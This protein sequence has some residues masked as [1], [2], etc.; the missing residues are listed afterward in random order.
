MVAR[1]WSQ[2]T[3]QDGHASLPALPCGACSL[4][5]TPPSWGR[6]QPPLSGCRAWEG[7]GAR[8]RALPPSS[9]ASAGTEGRHAGHATL[10][11]RQAVGSGFKSLALAPPAPVPGSSVWFHPARR[12]RHCP[13]LFVQLRQPTPGGGAAARLQCLAPSSCQALICMQ[14][15][16][17]GIYRGLALGSCSPLGTLSEGLVQ[18][19]RL[20][21]PFCRHAR[22]GH[23]PGRLRRN[24][25]H[26]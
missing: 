6:E 22:P 24:H 21:R 5:S 16:L 4:P 14:K 26:L 9:S 13:R 20:D 10:G 8:P 1:S 12:S 25:F 7:R 19:V 18:L 3:R 11:Q 23:S 2:A 15:G 17:G